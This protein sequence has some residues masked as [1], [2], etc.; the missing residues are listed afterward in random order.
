MT[1]IHAQEP[2]ARHPQFALILQGRGTRKP[3]AVRTR[4]RS[5]VQS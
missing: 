5:P 3:M 2:K 4:G 1:V